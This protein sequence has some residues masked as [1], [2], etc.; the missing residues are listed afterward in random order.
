MHPTQLFTH[1]H[2]WSLLDG[3]GWVHRGFLS[4]LLVFV[5]VLRQNL[6]ARLASNPTS[7]CLSFHDANHGWVPP[8]PNIAVFLSHNRLSVGPH[9][10]FYGTR[11][12]MFQLWIAYN[13][14]F[15]KHV[16]DYNN[17]LIGPPFAHSKPISRVYQ[18]S[19]TAWVWGEPFPSPQFS[20]LHL[21]NT[22]N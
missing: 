6:T 19:E 7:S 11:S 2:L 3:N 5:C 4:F 22:V 15:L 21:L 8:W 12:L 17:L 9:R 20:R 10:H 1:I 14:V 18:S 16:M 13:T